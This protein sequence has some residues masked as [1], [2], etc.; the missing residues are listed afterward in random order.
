MKHLIRKIHKYL[1]VLISIQL[2]LWTISGIYFAFNQIELVRGEQYRQDDKVSIDLSRVDLKVLDA[3]SIR[4]IK[5]LDAPALVVKKDNEIQYLDL[6]GNPLDKLSLQ[7]VQSIVG[8]STTLRVLGAEE[9]LI[10]EPGAEYRGRPLPLYRVRSINDEDEEINVYVAGF[11]GEVVAI[12]NEQWR[13]WD[14]MWGLHIMD[15]EER[16]DFN[17]WLLR[18]FSVLALISSV[19][20][21]F[22]FVR[23]DWK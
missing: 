22:L 12:R 17:H 19:T 1:S 18:V 20:G 13:I 16:D 6:M 3:D 14:L 11:S 2:L 23:L 4:F 8:S 21:L 7:E 5:R 10:P 9:V 15:W